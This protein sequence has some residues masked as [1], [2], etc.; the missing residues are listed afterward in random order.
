[1]TSS[2]EVKAKAS[3]LSSRYLKMAK[4][5]LFS[6][7]TAKIVFSDVEFWH[8]NQKFYLKNETFSFVFKHCANDF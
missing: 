6:P 3:F 4:D 7:K 8:K 1:M 2:K 5:V